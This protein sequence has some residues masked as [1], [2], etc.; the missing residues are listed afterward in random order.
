MIKSR[1]LQDLLCG[2]WK[3]LYITYFQGAAKCLEVSMEQRTNEV[4]WYVDDAIGAEYESW[5]G[6]DIVMLTAPTG[7]GKT[8]FILHTL[9]PYVISK[10]CKMLYLV[11]RKIL[12]NQ[13]EAELY[14]EVDQEIQ[15]C[16]MD[17][18][19]LNNY[20]QIR[21]YQSIEIL[22]KDDIGNLRKQLK[23]YDYV[24][25]DEAHYFYADAT[26]N[27]STELSY[28]C[29]RREFDDKIQIFISAT[30]KNMEYMIQDREA[31]YLVYDERD[32]VLRLKRLFQQTPQLIEIK[33]D[34]LILLETENQIRP[35]DQILRYNE[36]KKTH[37]MTYSVEKN[38]D[39]VNI[40]IF[41]ELEELVE[42][43]IESDQKWLIFVDSID[44]GNEFKKLLICDED[45]AANNKDKLSVDNVVFID[46]NY[47]EDERTA[48]DVKDLVV[49]KFIGKKVVIT[50]SVMDN[51]ISFL[52]NQLTN[53][54]IL[55]D[56][57]ES[58]IQM[59]G[60]KREDEKKLMLYISERTITHFQRRKHYI[61]ELLQFWN[62]Y[63]D[64]INKGLQVRVCDQNNISSVVTISSYARSLYL[65]GMSKKDI[66][67]S[68]KE[69]MDLYTI[70]FPQNK[71]LND[72]LSDTNIYRKASKMC[73]AVDGLLAINSFAIKRL[74]NLQNFYSEMIKEMKRDD[75]AFARMQMK[76]LGF[77]EERIERIIE[78]AKVRYTKPIINAIAPMIGKKFS[79]AENKKMK[80][81]IRKELKHFML[82]S[83]KCT[84]KI[85][86]KITR[87]DGAIQKEE[88]N[89]IMEIA[90]LPYVMRKEGNDFFIDEIA[91]EN[92]KSTAEPTPE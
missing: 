40:V 36:K 50:T 87:P 84:E 32:E 48:K 89:E 18:K 55:A 91:E 30:M 3:C 81:P 42:E 51:G 90:K 8:H 24:V 13:I 46:A 61:D 53:V 63:S 82:K 9:L 31:K 59:L 69:G 15:Q 33:R 17:V 47:E 76:W 10:G 78:E 25:Y 92:L 66:I 85:L 56:T 19:S 80:E 37:I 16:C 52:D 2:T 29:L 72:I 39:Y 21:T 4:K 64:S 70:L 6:G 22:V 65:R 27:T 79:S 43:I 28:D 38:Y 57:E 68:Y 12:K 23:A 20:I 88:F 49:K 60:R 75:S 1:N 74:R 71:L 77:E 73:Y 5:E 54:V 35:G 44:R 45:E 34:G 67:E 11:N 14:G 26:F 58:F 83:T 41:N 62:V 7:R 86:R